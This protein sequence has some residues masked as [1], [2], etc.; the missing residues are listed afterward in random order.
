MW[1]LLGPGLHTKDSVY[2]IIQLTAHCLE[3]CLVL[4]RGLSSD[5][6]NEW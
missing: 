1:I 3:L 2:N 5:L 6:I 4:D